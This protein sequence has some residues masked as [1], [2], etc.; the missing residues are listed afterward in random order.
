[1]EQDNPQ[2]RLVIARSDAPPPPKGNPGTGKAGNAFPGEPDAQPCLR[3]THTCLQH[4]TQLDCPLCVE[5]V[6]KFRTNLLYNLFVNMYYR[7]KVLLALIEVF[8]GNLR[9]TDC[10]KL[11][12]NFCQQTSKNHYDFFPYQYGPFSF[13]SYYDKCWLVELGMLKSADDFQ[14]NTKHS[15][16]NELIDADKSALLKFKR[17]IG[18]VRGDKL[19]KKTYREFPQFAARSTIADRLFDADELKHLRFAWNT[20]TKPIIFTI[21]Y[22][23]LT[24]DAFLNKLIANNITVVVDV[25]NNPQSMK[26]GFSKKSFKGYIEKA[27]MEYIHIPELGIPSSMRKGLGASVSHKSLFQKYETELLPNHE[28]AQKRLLTLIAEYARV[29][30]VCFEADH[31]SCHR[32]TLVENLQKKIPLPSPVLHL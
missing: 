28:E 31:H 29:A 20:D 1:M 13:I 27:G 25:R 18:D 4:T 5:H 2:V 32:N 9:N 3:H 6:M 17:T 22:E 21:G 30:L 11:L 23:G 26:Y 15:Y 24:I 12:F 8:G 14:L 16:L 19:V 7:R 10:E